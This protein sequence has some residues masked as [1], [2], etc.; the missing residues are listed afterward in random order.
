M[1]AAQ[2]TNGALVASKP[3]PVTSST[4]FATVARGM[5]T[6]R[7]EAALSDIIPANILGI[8]QPAFIGEIWKNA[9][10][11]RKVVPLLNQAV[12]TNFNVAGWEWGTKPAVG[13]YTGSKTD[14]PSNTPTT[15]AH[16]K[17]AQRFAGGHDIDRRYVDFGNTEFIAAYFAAMTESYK[18]QTDAY[19]LEMLIAS[20][21]NVAAQQKHLAASGAPAGV[22]TALWLIVEGVAQIIADTDQVPSFALVEADLWKPLLYTKADDVLAYLNAALSFTEGTLNGGF[23]IVPMATGSLADPDADGG[24]ADVAF[25]G[26]VLVGTKQA[27]THHELGGGAP[28]RVSAVDIAKGGQDEA[29]F[30]YSLVDVTQPKGFVLLDT[31]S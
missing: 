4:L 9:P 8:E 5:Q 15:V 14:I 27:A 18:R 22:P 13:K 21:H 7:M 30:G 29:L 6:G 20:G 2:V 1:S 11:E 26:K 28:I 31:P 23:K 3:E 12:L 24:G 25:A 17:T 10:F 16:T 19:A